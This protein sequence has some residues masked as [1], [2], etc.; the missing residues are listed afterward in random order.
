MR[1]LVLPFLLLPL[2]SGEIADLSG[3]GTDA[4]RD[5]LRF[6]N[7]QSWNPEFLAFTRTKPKF[8]PA[9]WAA[10]IGIPAPPANSSPRTRAELE[11]L[12]KVRDL[13]TERRE[14]V[15]KELISDGFQFGM[16]R[17]GDFVKSSDHVATRRMFKAIDTDLGIIIF[18]LKQRFDRVRP[19]VLDTKLGHLFPVPDHPAYPSGHSTQAFTIAYLLRELDPENADSYLAAALRIARNREIAG[20]H[21][22][23]DTDAGRLAARQFVD[24]LLAHAEFK[25]LLEAAR[26]EW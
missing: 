10:R 18:T 16:H 2:H 26:D 7:T 22:P 8:L 13:R 11:H 3:S 4:E 6:S 5:K 24:L 23:S 14:E 1:L 15:R 25:V 21:Y 9:D 17:Y 19:T 20:F 12:Q